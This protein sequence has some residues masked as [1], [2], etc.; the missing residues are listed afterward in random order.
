MVT[1]SQSGFNYGKTKYP[2]A[3]SIYANVTCNYSHSAG[4][5]VL[6]C[7]KSIETSHLSKSV[8]YVNI[9]EYRSSPGYKHLIYVSPVHMSKC[10]GDQQVDLLTAVGIVCSLGTWFATASLTC[11]L[12][13]LW[14]VHGLLQL[15]EDLKLLPAGVR[16]MKADLRGDNVCQ[17]WKWRARVPWGHRES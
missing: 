15:G 12:F 8:F 6:L 9:L 5:V 3:K 14:A 1:Q 13:R 7:F 2:N 10:L 17:V 4:I 11:Q 16:E